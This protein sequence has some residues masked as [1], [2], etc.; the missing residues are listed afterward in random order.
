MIVKI[1]NSASKDFHGVKY[2]DKKIN[3]EKGE[4]MLMKNFPSFI[5]AQS[6]QDEVRNYLKSVSQ[7][8][9]TQKPQFHAVIS[10]KYQ[11]HS[12]EQLTDIA[13][14]FMKRMGYEGQPYL[15][16]FHKDTENNHVHIVSTRVDKKTGKKIN[17]S[18]EKLKSQQALAKAMEKVLGVNREAELD[19][20]LQ[21][22]F[23]N[24]QQLEKLLERNGFKLS[25]SEHTPGKLHILHNGVVQKTLQESQLRY[26]EPQKGDR[27]TKQIKAFIEKYKEMYSN[28]VFKVLDDRAEKGLYAINPDAQREPIPPKIE[29]ASELQ[30]KLKTIFGIDIAFHH[31]DDQQPFGYTIIDNKT[32]QVY[33]GSEIMKLKEAFVLTDSSI[34]KKDFERF[35][36]YNLR[37][38]AERQILLQYLAKE[39]VV[40]QPFMLFDN[41]RLKYNE[42]KADFQHLKSDVWK[43]IKT[44]EKDDVIALERDDKGD[45]YAI[46]LRFHQIYRLDKLLGQENYQQFLAGEIKD[47]TDYPAINT[48]ET[49]GKTDL[50]H[51]PAEDVSEVLKEVENVFKALAK[52]SY[53]KRD[54]TE[55]EL[56]KRRKKRR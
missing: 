4:L 40:A 11:E 49:Q 1:L 22:K 13:D 55:D 26:R 21:Y 23:S 54:T 34:G 36:D 8:E 2:N 20:L 44:P 47:V 43:H 17:D 28:K 10:T 7:G 33:K 50:T 14:E 3:S 16:V 15:V 30:E 41:K 37:S 29:F 24:L 18:F 12:K 51:S 56:R 35:K 52:D 6:S 32:G 19:R 31:K 27:H 38:D 45:Y 39:G 9:R 25:Q 48:S 5:N 42:N 46:H 53:T